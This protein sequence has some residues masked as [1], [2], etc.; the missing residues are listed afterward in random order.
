MATGWQVGVALLT[1]FQ[2]VKR[3]FC[4]SVGFA[5]GRGEELK[6]AIR[7]V[8]I[9]SGVD[10][11]SINSLPLPLTCHG[12]PRTRQS[13]TFSLFLAVTATPVSVYSGLCSK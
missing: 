3:L 2:L 11:C 10:F 6:A 13:T 4:G 8:Y 1:T 12:R 9:E 7:K 5:V